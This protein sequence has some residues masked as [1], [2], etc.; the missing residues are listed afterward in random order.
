MFEPW[1]DIWSDW[2]PAI[3]A[4]FFV[5]VAVEFALSWL[6]TAVESQEQVGGD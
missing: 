2:M 4:F 3:V 6:H 5:L 1:G